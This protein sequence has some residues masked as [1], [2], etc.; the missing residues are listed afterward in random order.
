MHA[1]FLLEML[2]VMYGAGYSRADINVA[3]ELDR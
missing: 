1:Q 2:T 3:E